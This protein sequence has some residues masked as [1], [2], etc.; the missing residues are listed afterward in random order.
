[1][2]YS[3]LV[4][5]LTAGTFGSTTS[6]AQLPTDLP[7]RTE[8]SV[9]TPPPAEITPTSSR[10]LRRAG[11]APTVS[12]AALDPS[13][14]RVTW[15]QVPDAVGYLV[16]RNPATA[17]QLLTP[18]PITATELIDKELLPGSSVSYEVSA[19]FGAQSQIAPGRSSIVTA[20]TPPP[21]NPT[22]FTAQTSS[23]VNPRI[24]PEPS[25]SVSLGWTRSPGAAFYLV[26]GDGQL[27][28]QGTD[29]ATTLRDIRKGEHYYELVAYY[30]PTGAA[31]GNTGAPATV[32]AYAY[33]MRVSAT[34]VGPVT[35]MLQWPPVII[36]FG[37]HIFRQT[38][39][40]ASPQLPPPQA[41]DRRAK[42]QKKN[43]FLETYLEKG[44]TYRYF[45]YADVYGPVT[46]PSG[47]VRITVPQ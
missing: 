47:A 42:D 23:F 41:K 43:E 44:T 38:V 11:E 39:D 25:Y 6:A 28:Y 34:M 29:P 35:V 40:P 8:P 37:Y 16:R 30:G 33:P 17:P 4:P 10:D 3:L 36:A 32:W 27:V 31:I 12:A 21:E 13:E 7:R 46:T 19:D 1:M 26:K 14:I 20:T 45:V 9:Y 24:S 18:A 22:G 2:R 5:L 15:N